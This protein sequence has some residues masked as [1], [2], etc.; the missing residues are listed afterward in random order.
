M[1][2]GEVIGV[3]PFLKKFGIDKVQ[4]SHEARFIKL[5]NSPVEKYLKQQQLRLLRLSRSPDR[6]RFWKLAKHLLR[7][8]KSFRM[9][10]LRNVDPLWYAKKSW[11][12][13]E[14]NLKDL[15]GICYRPPQTFEIKRVSIP[16][17]Q[18][19]VRFI[20]DAGIPMRCYLWMWNLMLHYFVNE[21][22]YPDQHG[23]RM[24]KGTVTC[25]KRI[26]EEVI[27]SKF[28]YEFDYKKFHDL[29][30]RKALAEALIRF[31]FPYKITQELV[32]LSSAYVKGAQE[33]D[34]L[35]LKLFGDQLPF[36]HYYRGV[37][38][39][40][41]IAALL[42]LVVL[43]DLKVYYLK[44][45]KYLGYADDGILYGDDP[46]VKEEW[47]SKLRPGTGVEYKP[48]KSGWVKYQGY[49]KKNLK[50]VGLEYNPYDDYISSS[51]HSGKTNMMVWESVEEL[52]EP[53]KELLKLNRQ[54]F[55]DMYGSECI[56]GYSAKNKLTYKDS[57]YLGI[58]SSKVWS[59]KQEGYMTTEQSRRHIPEGWMLNNSLL[60]IIPLVDDV[61]N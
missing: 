18:G 44:K 57:E 17:P 37:V 35:R 28:I 16:K 9:L 47:L 48:E 6:E 10:A 4:R 21:R 20:N 24:G 30:D 29:I 42:A 11:K 41:N 23:H 40:S 3:D 34:P 46:D 53:V 50:F 14:R 38:Q 54:G 26:I 39:G 7:S 43:E 59:S 2:L 36:H 49:W 56:R 25:W 27:D 22:L 12:Q 33:E 58:I 13:V 51:T 19:G 8:S 31:G 15:N 1:N 5:R 55:I 60:S 52:M 32:H 45:G 61:K